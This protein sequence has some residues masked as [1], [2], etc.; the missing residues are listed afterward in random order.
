MGMLLRGPMVSKPSPG[1]LKPLHEAAMAV[2]QAAPAKKLNI[3]VLNK[4]LF[5]LDLIALRDFG[6]VITGSKFIAIDN[7]PVVAKYEA[8]LVKPL[9]QFG[10]A[11]QRME[12]MAK[13]VE[14]IKTLGTFHHLDANDLIKVGVVTEKLGAMSS[15]KVSKF[16]HA[17]PGWKLAYNGPLVAGGVINMRVAM[18]Q[19]MDPDPWLDAPLST[20]ELASLSS[21]D[22]ALTDW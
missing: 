14:A 10:L 9:V 8:A 1:V 15:G 18:Q 21:T 5:Y 11:V 12:G 22:D 2:L 13:P 3:V 16:A 7:G 6:R 4:V 20:R 17:N 19:L